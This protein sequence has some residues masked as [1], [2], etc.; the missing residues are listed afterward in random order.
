MPTGDGVSVEIKIDL[1]IKL[2]KRSG[3]IPNLE[4]IYSLLDWGLLCQLDMHS[5]INL[6]T[7][8]SNIKV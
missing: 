1:M 8:L 4:Q 6:M 3:R 2:H 7:L 5:T